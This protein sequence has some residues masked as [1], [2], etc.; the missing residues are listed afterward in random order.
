MYTCIHVYIHAH[1]H[2]SISMLSMMSIYDLHI[3]KYTFA[4]VSLS[5]RMWFSTLVIVLAAMT[6]EAAADGVPMPNERF[7][8]NMGSVSYLYLCIWIK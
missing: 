1:T 6:P 4:A 3:Y 2:I 8:V 5:M 7:E